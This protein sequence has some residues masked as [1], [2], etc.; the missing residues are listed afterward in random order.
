LSEVAPQNPP[1]DRK[2]FTGQERDFE[3]GLDYFGAR[4]YRADL[5]RFTM[6]DSLMTI[7]KNSADPQ[8]WNRYAYGRNSPL[9]FVDPDG[10]DVAPIILFIKGEM[11]L[12]FVDTRIVEK[13][14]AFLEEAEKANIKVEFNNVFRTEEQQAD[15]PPRDT[16]TH[17]RCPAPTAPP[18]PAM[19]PRR[20]PPVQEAGATNL[21]R[22]DRDAARDLTPTR[23]TRR[24]Q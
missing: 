15:L 13:V 24:M 20:M 7:D 19:G 9:R 22:T 8:R 3:T 17:R 1:V 12:T 10:K 21:G 16:R 5:G 6:I 11:R 18:A 14:A 2:L 23:S 4:Y